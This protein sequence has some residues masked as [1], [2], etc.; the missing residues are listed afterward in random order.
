MAHAG[1]PEIDEQRLALEVSKRRRR[2]LR[3]LEHDS[4]HCLAASTCRQ[5]QPVPGPRGPP[6]G[7]MMRPRL[8]VQGRVLIAPGQQQGTTPEEAEDFQS[9]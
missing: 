2:A 4:R 5:C 1:G 3:V 7:Q 9:Q 8:A 6:I